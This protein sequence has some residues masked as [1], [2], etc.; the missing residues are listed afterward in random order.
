MNWNDFIKII[1]KNYPNAKPEKV[2]NMVQTIYGKKKKESNYQVLRASWS[3][4][5]RDSL[6]LKIGTS[7][8]NKKRAEE[9]ANSFKPK[10]AEQ[11]SPRGRLAQP[12]T[13]R[14]TES[15]ATERRLNNEM[16]GQMKTEGLL[17][18]PQTQTETTPPPPQNP[19]SRE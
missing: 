2:L 10:F 18:T 7:K 12:G 16:V 13:Q 3:M 19:E 9:I 8:D 11:R 15:T 1:K 5:V 4:L 17:H 6:A 14:N